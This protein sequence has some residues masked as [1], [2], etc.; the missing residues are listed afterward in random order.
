MSLEDQDV[1]KLLEEM[2]RQI[3]HQRMM[4][5]MHAAELASLKTELANV[6]TAVCKGDEDMKTDFK[7]Y[8]QR[9][10]E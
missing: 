6:K 9:V 10:A 1:R 5:T 4:L 3:R 8:Q 2:D 7:N